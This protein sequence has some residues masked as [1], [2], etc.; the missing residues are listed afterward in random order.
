MPPSSSKQHIRIHFV[1]VLIRYCASAATP[2]RRPSRSTSPAP[3]PAATQRRAWR[4]SPAAGRPPPRLRPRTRALRPTPLGVAP[5]PV[6][7]SWRGR[8]AAMRCSR[9]WPRWRRRTRR[10][11]PRTRASAVCWVVQTPR[12]TTPCAHTPWWA[13]GRAAARAPERWLC[14]VV[15]PELG[16]SLGN[17]ASCSARCTYSTPLCG[18]HPHCTPQAVDPNNPFNAKHARQQVRPTQK[19]S[20]CVGCLA[21]VC[22]GCCPGPAHMGRHA[23]QTIAH[24]H[25]ILL[26]SPFFLTHL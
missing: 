25:L 17:S 3:T 16:C 8:R 4:R 21:A 14:C 22:V 13:G 19:G 20:T 12:T 6:A 1:R 2:L 9:W 10:W 23:H 26:H 15:P 24:L 7:C 5:R 11:R 18:D